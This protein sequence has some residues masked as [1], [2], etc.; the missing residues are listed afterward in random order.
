PT[1]V[2]YH[3]GHL[4]GKGINQQP[5]INWS[6][7]MDFKQEVIADMPSQIEAGFKAQGIDM[8]HEPASFLSENVLSV[9]EKEIKADKIV[10]ATG[11]RP[12]TLEFPG[13]EFAKTSSDFLDLPEMPESV[14]FIGGGY[15]GFEFAHIA[16]RAGA[17]VTI[18]HRSKKPLKNFE[19]D[20]VSHL[21][22]ASEDLGIN[23]VL[24]TEVCGIEK[25]NTG[26]NVKGNYNGDNRF[27]EADLVFNSAG[28]VPDIS[29]LNL[30]KAG[31]EF[32]QRGIIVNEYFQSFTNPNVYAAGD[33]AATE[34][35]PLTPVSTLEGYLAADNI[36]EPGTKK[37][38]YPPIPSVVF[39]LPT[40]ASV[41]LTETE[42]EKEGYNYKVNYQDAS[43]WFNAKIRQVPE[44]AFKVIINKDT[45]TILGAHLIGPNAEEVINLFALY[46]KTG[47]EVTE[48]KRMVFTYPTLASDIKYML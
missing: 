4:K 22:K 14:L 38:E 17:D 7:L 20:I 44:Y 23:L 31:V 46:I 28:R 42:A 48:I 26:Y 13:A 3:A 37:V 39:T 6:D 43:G 34:G 9:G 19:Q 32:N 16:A 18:V 36:L 41:G 30:D 40:M 11:A 25:L 35:L 8:Y 2:S 15:I 12:R 5:E 29:E 45:D 1:E 27:F 21:I 33:V 47:M 24:E 10:I